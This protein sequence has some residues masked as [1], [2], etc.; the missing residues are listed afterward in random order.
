MNT[1]FG[2]GIQ[3]ATWLENILFRPR[4]IGLRSR[5]LGFGNSQRHLPQFLLNFEGVLRAHAERMLLHRIQILQ[6]A[7][8][9]EIV[10]P[11]PLLLQ[12]NLCSH[13]RRFENFLNRLDSSIHINPP[14]AGAGNGESAGG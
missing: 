13:G 10:D 12:Q 14:G 9:L 8:G 7:V 11:F 6:G 4:V 3:T 2:T 5:E 1:L